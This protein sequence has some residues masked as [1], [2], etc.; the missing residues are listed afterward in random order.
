MSNGLDL[1]YGCIISV[2]HSQCCRRSPQGAYQFLFYSAVPEERV[3][4][5]IKSGCTGMIKPQRAQRTQS[6][7]IER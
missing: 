7:R 4:N 5:N 2:L 1:L 6:P 3:L